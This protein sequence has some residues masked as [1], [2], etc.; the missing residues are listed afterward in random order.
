[1]KKTTTFVICFMLVASS[2]LIIIPIKNVKAVTELTLGVP[3]SDALEGAQ[4]VK[5]YQVWVNAGEHL[6]VFL[7]KPNVWLGNLGIKYGVLPTE[8][9]NDGWK[10]DWGDSIVEINTTHGPGYYYIIVCGSDFGYGAYNITAMTT[11]SP[12]QP[13][14]QPTITGLNS[15]KTG[16][17]YDYKFLATD[18]EGDKIY[19]IIDWGDNTSELTLG[20]Y[21]SGYETGVM[22]SWNTEG[23]YTIKAKTRDAVGIESDWATLTVTM[24]YSYNK[25]IS[26]F[27]Q[28]LYQRFPNAF[29]LLRQ[30]MGY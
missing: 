14:S 30:L 3:L 23:T 28:L 17:E 10:N 2:L 13:P 6:F 29:P 16:K 27:F 20:P 7:D 26:Q 25:S 12:N 21:D 1:M 15:G 5:Y 19:Y 11:Q 24:P 18:P 8:S 4:D 22:H 9:D